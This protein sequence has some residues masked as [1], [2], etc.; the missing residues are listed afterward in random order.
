MAK[1]IFQLLSRFFAHYGYGAVFFGVMLENTGLPV[2]GESVLLFGS[3]LAHQDV[4]RLKWVIVAA[5]LGAIAGDNAGYV[6]GY[7]GGAALL[8]RLR[9]RAFF[10]EHRFDQAESA[11]L[12]YGASAVF[13][14]RFITGLRILAGP[15]AGAFRMR[16][17]RFLLANVAGA[18]AWAAT[19]GAAG[20]LLGTSWDR[21]VRFAGRLDW[22]VLILAAAILIVVWILRRR[23]SK[24]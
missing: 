24:T 8:R 23:G 21:L 9:G 14:A 12:R 20:Y 19:V 18:M 6:I 7:Y 16:Y 10:P 22:A 11:V 17:S 5:I 15:L 13:V 3:F 4:L 2:P 1:L